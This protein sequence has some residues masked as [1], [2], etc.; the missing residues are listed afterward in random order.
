LKKRFASV[1]A[2]SDDGKAFGTDGGFSF[3][4]RGEPLKGN[5]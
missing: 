2:D 5:G 4:N 3:F 1:V